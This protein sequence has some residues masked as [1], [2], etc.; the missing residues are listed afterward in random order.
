MSIK[1]RLIVLC[2]LSSV[3]PVSLVL[4]KQVPLFFD[5]LDSMQRQVLEHALRE[6]QGLAFDDIFTLFHRVMALQRMFKAFCPHM[7]Q[8]F[9][10]AP[11]FEP[12]VEHWLLNT[13]K[14]TAEWVD[15][16]VRSDPFLPIESTGVYHSSSI[17]DLFGALQQPLEFIQ[18][19][20]WPDKHMQAR[21]LTSLSRIFSNAIE[22]Y[23]HRVEEMFMEE[24]FPRIADAQDTQQKQSAW[25]IKAKQTLQGEKKVEPF[26]FQVQ[27]S[28][29]ARIFLIV[30]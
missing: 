7:Q 29:T 18:S 8:Q 9:E 1:S 12:H 2:A 27:V 28:S 5:D 3:D 19:L 24:M 30:R 22:K 26:H 11:W 14:K 17:D 20:K 25:M 6:Q 13:G 10:I 23:C 21:F 16:A 15:A 4:E